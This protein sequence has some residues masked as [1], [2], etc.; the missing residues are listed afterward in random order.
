MEQ[1]STA[2]LHFPIMIFASFILFYCVIWIVLGSQEFILKFRYVF[3]LSILV[4]VFGM[5]FGKFGANGGLP[6]WIYYPVP[7][8]MNVL[9]P[10]IVL[11]INAKK[12]ALYLLLSF[13]SAPIIHLFFS[14]FLGWNEYMPFWKVPTFDIL[15]NH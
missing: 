4:V 6:W 11:K 2:F 14:F 1:S 10:P 8:L 5:L 13:L 12:T 15:F 7:M 9:L 3:I